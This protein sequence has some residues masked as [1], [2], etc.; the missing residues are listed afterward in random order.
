MADVTPSAAISG[1]TAKFTF[2]STTYHGITNY[3][4]SGRIEKE[5]VKMSSSTGV[6]SLTIAGGPEDTIALD[7][8]IGQG[9]DVTL[10]ALKRGT[11]STTCEL[12]PEGDTA[13][14]IEITFEAG[15]IDSADFGAAVGQAGILSLV[16]TCNGDLTIQ[17]AT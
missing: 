4:Y 8:V 7:I 5:V 13:G 14:N 11:T 3:R 1:G 17:A 10:A 12:H 15:I 6:T 9:D 16:V 2:G